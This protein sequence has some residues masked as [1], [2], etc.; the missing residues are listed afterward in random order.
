VSS[1]PAAAHSVNFARQYAQARASNAHN[2][3]SDENDKSKPPPPAIDNSGSA[4]QPPDPDDGTDVSWKG[5]NVRVKQLD[6]TKDELKK[7]L[8]DNGYSSWPSKDG[9]AEI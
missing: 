1:K 8:K 5:A 4:A 7:I 2:S 9:Q 3:E 6:L